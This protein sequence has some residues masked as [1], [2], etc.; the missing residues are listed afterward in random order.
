MYKALRNQ[1]DDDYEIIYSQDFSYRNHNNHRRFGEADFVVWHPHQGLLVLEVKGGRSI[2]KQPDGTWRSQRHDDGTWNTIRDPF[3]QAQSAMHALKDELTE[4]MR[5]GKIDI[6][7]AFASVF[8]DAELNGEMPVGHPPE[9]CIDARAMKQLN[10]A[11]KGALRAVAT[12]F[13]ELDS[14]AQQ[15]RTANLQTVWNELTHTFRMIP[16]G[17]IEG[18][19]TRKATIEQGREL[20]HQLTEQQA[21]LYYETLQSNPRVLV[22][23]PA[24]TGKTLLA[25][26][27]AKQLAGEGKKTLLLCYNRL[28]AQHLSEQTRDIDNLDTRYFHEIIEKNIIHTTR[29]RM[30]AQPDDAFWVEESSDLLLEIIENR[31]I[32]YD[33]LVVDEAQDIYSN[34]WDALQFL[35]TE[36]PNVYVFAD[37]HQN[38]Y[39]PQLSVDTAWDDM[40]LVRITRNC[41]ATQRVA[42]YAATMR[43]V[44]PLHHHPS[45]SKGVDVKEHT[46]KNA[47]EQAEMLDTL[48]RDLRADGFEANQIILLAMH[49][50][51]NTALA[52]TKRL[53]G[54][55]LKSF[56]LGDPPTNQELSYST[57]QRFKGL[58]APVVIVYGLD[59]GCDYA[60]HL[61]FMYVA[62]TRAQDRL[63]VMHQEDWAPPNPPE[64]GRDG[65][66]A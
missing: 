26:N 19:S 20:Y 27:R 2:E 37:I 6:P 41:R 57:A 55:E 35:L 16:A 61:N 62:C 15:K 53:G 59:A 25:E 1:L 47:D 30:P 54:Y 23:G 28:L 11:V 45:L 3:V 63:H 14:R 50:K 38:I 29:R 9:T 8:P 65:G 49:S 58:D 46:Y 42:E 43:G 24:G 66:M 32:Q 52:D 5:E 34:W 48:V 18:A 64:S 44:T 22:R 33:A 13:A 39:G 36:D 60:T 4:R 7:H 17:D 40:P 31:E 51:K 56:D 21:A 12:P 10:S